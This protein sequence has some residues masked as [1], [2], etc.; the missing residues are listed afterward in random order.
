MPIII[1]P[2]VPED[3]PD[4]LDIFNRYVVN[5]MEA[6][7]EQPLPAP[8]F[9]KL[10]EAAKGLPGVTARQDGRCVGFALLRPYHQLPVFSRTA[11]LTIFLHPEFK[12][13]GIGRQL[14]GHLL[15]EAKN[16]G[17]V[18]ILAAI[19]SLNSD[20]VAFHQALGFRECGCFQ[21]VGCKNGR[22]FDLRYFQYFC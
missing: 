17:L 11:E 21:R 7:P 5:G 12:R 8:V 14:M 1:S 13:R 15:D 16:Q 18:S 19:S 4:L 10:L 9:A 20:S 2:L 6:F 22:E 3:A